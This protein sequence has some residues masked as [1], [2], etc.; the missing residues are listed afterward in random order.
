MPGLKVIAPYTAADHKGLLKSAIRDPN[1]VIFLENELVYG[2]SFAVPDRRRFHRADRQGA[3]RARRRARHHRRLFAHGA[4]WRW[5]PPTRLQ[6][7]GIEAE[8]IDLRTLRPLDIETV[9]ASVKKTNRLVSG[10]GGLALRRHRRP[11]SRRSIMEHAFDWLD[12]PVVRVTGKD[13]PLPY[14]A[15]LER[16]A[17]PQSDDIAAAAKAVATARRRAM[18]IEVLMPALSPTMTEGNLAKWHKKEGDTVKAGDVLAEIETDKA[19]MEIRGGRRGHARPHPRARRRAGRQGQRA[20][21]G[22]PRRGRGQEHACREAR[23]G[24]GGE[25]CACCGGAGARAHAEACCARARRGGR[26]S[27]TISNPRPT[28]ERAG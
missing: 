9:V 18:P 10:R 1:P 5:R 24:G 12:A 17:L 3:H 19:T 8:V 11:R 25:A 28:G 27:L 20:D 21:R 4:A 6:P 2:Q 7:T 26:K 22:D 15:N 23:A 14:A 16:L 13:V